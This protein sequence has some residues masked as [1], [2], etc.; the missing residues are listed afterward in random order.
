MK[1]RQTRRE[2]LKSIPILGALAVA[3]GVFLRNFILYLFPSIEKKR[4]HKYLVCK[5]DEL[6]VGKAKRLDIGG[7]P[8]YVVRL[9]EGYRVFSGI[10]TH[11]GCI[12][13]WEE[14]KER[15]FCPCHKGVYAKD[16]RVLKG[17]PPRPLDR[18]KVEVKNDLV[19]MYIEE[20]IRSPWT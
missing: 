1:E 18:Y 10:C 2:F 20:R 17:P 13:R 7:K 5:V 4:Y 16:G 15:F 6:E 3:F 19:F 9:K 8:V 14:Q 11:L 12:I